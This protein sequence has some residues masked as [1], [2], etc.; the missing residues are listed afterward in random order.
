MATVIRK[1]IWLANACKLS[2][3][4]PVPLRFW[5]VTQNPLVLG[6]RW[7]FSLGKPLLSATS[8]LIWC[9]FGVKRVPSQK[10]KNCPPG[11][12]D[13]LIEALKG[14]KNKHGAGAETYPEVLWVIVQV[15][16]ALCD[17]SSVLFP[18]PLAENYLQEV[19]HPANDGDVP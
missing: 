2:H 11:K 9:F 18:F 14:R 5:T 8:M 17:G 12:I 15:L 16:E 7:Y 3:C 10:S 4:S 6:R 19:P 13:W 1:I